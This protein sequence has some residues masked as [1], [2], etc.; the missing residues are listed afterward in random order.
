MIVRRSER[1]HRALGVS[2][3]DEPLEKDGFGAANVEARGR[4]EVRFAHDLPLPHGTHQPPA[5]R[6][7]SYMA[8]QVATERRFSAGVPSRRHSNASASALTGRSRRYQ[9]L[10]KP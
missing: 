7:A 10:R 6:P 9:H 4:D 2:L 5:F 3:A 1:A 8:M